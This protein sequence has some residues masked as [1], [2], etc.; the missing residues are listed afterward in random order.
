[1]KNKPNASSEPAAPKAA[2]LEKELAQ[3]RSK[4][5]KQEQVLSELGKSEKR[6]RQLIENANNIILSQKPDGQIVFANDYACEFYGYTK[7]ELL[8]KN[9]LDLVPEIERTGRDLKTQLSKIF[10]S[11]DDYS[12]HENENILADGRRVW[13]AWTNR[14]IRDEQGRVVE[15]LAIG[16]DATERKEAEKL[17]L[18]EREML[19]QLLEAQEKE[20]RLIA[21]EIHDGL[22]QLIIAA[23]MQFQSCQQMFPDYPEL[24]Q[25]AFNVGMESMDLTLAETRRLISGLRPPILDEKGVLPAID[26]LIES[27]PIDSGA[28]ID[29][30]YQVDFERLEPMIENSLFR[31]TQESLTNALRY[32]QAKSIKI[33]LEE[34]DHTILLSICDDGIGFDP[35]SVRE[36]HFGL[37]GIRERALLMGGQAEIDSEPGKGTR[38]RV[39]LPLSKSAPSP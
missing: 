39:E 6:Y 11:P 22:A 30:S 3:L 31:I 9:S 33:S 13:I 35:D 37:K 15:A 10:Q 24:A 32:S 7:E 4:L 29:F 16:Q 38:I 17:V 14:S 27:M 19:R 2:D 23:K 28:E 5:Q 12:T 25:K 18:E 21:F 8:Q 36:N 26:H 1:M 20:R 34:R